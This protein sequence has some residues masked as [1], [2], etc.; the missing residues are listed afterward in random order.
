MI[1]NAYVTIWSVN[2]NEDGRITARFSES[3]KDK[4]TGEYKTTFTGYAVIRDKAIANTIADNW[5]GEKGAF[6]NA[7]LAL[8][9]WYDKV[10]KKEHSNI[11]MLGFE[12]YKAEDK[13]INLG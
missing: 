4:N 12:P 8:S 11:C 1:A 6:G 3:N 2:E 7:T 5:R 13:K 9:N 10:A